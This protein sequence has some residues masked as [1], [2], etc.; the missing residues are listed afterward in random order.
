MVG[1]GVSNLGTA[2]RETESNVPL[3]PNARRQVRSEFGARV[4]RTGLT[5]FM[6]RRRG[7]YPALAPYRVGSATSAITGAA[8]T[9]IG[10]LV[11]DA[12]ADGPPLAAVDASAVH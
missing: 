12:Y 3:P 1:N 9:T 10:P 2:T 11:A 7:E 5:S 4:L 6:T 8:M